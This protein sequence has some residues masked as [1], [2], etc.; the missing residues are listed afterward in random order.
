MHL[1]SKIYEKTYE[2]PFKNK[3]DVLILKKMFN[4]E[5]GKHPLTGYK[6][7]KYDLKNNVYLKSYKHV[8]ETG[9][10]RASTARRSPLG[11]PCVYVKNVI[12]YLLDDTIKFVKAWI[13]GK[14]ELIEYFIRVDYDYK[15][16]QYEYKAADPP[17]PGLRWPWQRQRTVISRTNVFGRRDRWTVREFPATSA[18]DEESIRAI[19]ILLIK[20]YIVS[21]RTK[22][23]D[24]NTILSVGLNSDL[25]GSTERV[26]RR[27]AEL[28]RRGIKPRGVMYYFKYRNCLMQMLKYFPNARAYENSFSPYE[29]LFHTYLF[30]LDTKHIS[31]SYIHMYDTSARCLQRL[32]FE[33]GNSRCGMLETINELLKKLHNT[34]YANTYTLLSCLPEDIV[35]NIG[36]YFVCPKLDYG[37]LSYYMHQI[38]I[39]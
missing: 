20:M 3:P 29:Q 4:G 18:H 27:T 24:D 16:M 19:S 25:I 39:S 38:H 6:R 37:E 30:C 35:K 10:R 13:L 36:E 2:T 17:G 31:R 7:L 23:N 12:E 21:Q 15:K 32:K 1:V 28:R 33:F 5:L 8:F 9:E 26:T 22:Y 14:P 34:K 11:Q